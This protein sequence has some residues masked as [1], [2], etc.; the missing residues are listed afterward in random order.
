MAWDHMASHHLSRILKSGSKEHMGEELQLALH[1]GLQPLHPPTAK[2]QAWLTRK[3]SPRRCL[4]FSVSCLALGLN[5]HPGLFVDK[6]LDGPTKA[7]RIKAA[8]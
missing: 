3:E 4:A 6:E 2:I 8:V 1:L 5:T 7:P